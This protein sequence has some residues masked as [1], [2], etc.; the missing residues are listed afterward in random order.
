MTPRTPNSC[1]TP[2]SILAF[3]FSASSSTE[4][5]RLAGLVSMPSG[6]RSKPVEGLA[7]SKATWLSSIVARKGS[8]DATG[9]RPAMRGTTTQKR[10]APRKMAATRRSGVVT[11]PSRSSSARISS[12]PPGSA[13]VRDRNTILVRTRWIARS[14]RAAKGT[15]MSIQVPKLRS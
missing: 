5:T 7:K 15:P 12:R 1:S 13:W 4:A 6:G 8:A 11:E 2:S 3:C 9:P 10:I 14:M